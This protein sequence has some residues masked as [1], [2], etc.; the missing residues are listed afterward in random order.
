M[1]ATVWR[2]PILWELRNWFA[3]KHRSYCV[4]EVPCCSQND[5]TFSTFVH[6]GRLHKQRQP[7]IFFLRSSWSFGRWP[8]GSLHSLGLSRSGRRSLGWTSFRPFVERIEVRNS[9]P[10]IIT[11][12]CLC[13]AFLISFIIGP[14]T[15]SKNINRYWKDMC[16]MCVFYRGVAWF[17]GRDFYTFI[18]G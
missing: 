14:V 5:R 1:L 8:R 15:A 18:L 2:S 12:F 9:F 16:E 17:L 10:Q 13:I 3:S 6:L 4:T 11:A 7:G